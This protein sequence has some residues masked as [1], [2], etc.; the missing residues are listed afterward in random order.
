[1]AGKSP[2]LLS[3]QRSLVTEVHDPKTSDLVI[4][5]RGLGLQKIVCTLLQIYDGP[6]NLVLLI[7]ASGEEEKSI[8]SQLG[9]MGVRNPGLR[10]VDYEMSK[11]DRQLLYKKGG[12]ISVTSRILVVD[13]LQTDIPVELITGMVILHAEKVTPTSLESFVVRLFRKENKDGFVK[14]FSDQPEQ[15]T[16]GMFPLKS[17]ITELQLKRTHIYPRFHE[18]VQTS[19]S[20]RKADV[21]E[22]YV[23]MTPKMQD[24]HQGIVHCISATLN[25]LKKSNST[26][27]LD[28][29]TVEN[30]YFAS[31]DSIV[32]RQLDPVWH[33]IRPKTKQLVSDLG[34]LRR[35]LNYLLALDPITFHSYLES[36]VASNS[37]T[38][39]HPLVQQ[40]KSDW[41]FTEA[42]HIIITTAKARCYT[43]GSKQSVTTSNVD[44]DWA[45]LDE[46]Q[47]TGAAQDSGSQW[48]PWMPHEMQPVLEE[49]G[50][51]RVLAEV[52]L[53]IEHEMMSRPSQ[54]MEPGTNTVLVMVNDHRTATL[55]QE[56]LSSMHHNPDSP[57]RPLLERRLR[58]YLWWKSMLS[59]TDEKRSDD[60]NP[61]IPAR[62]S[63]QDDGLS[64][65]LRRKDQQKA[66]AKQARRRVRGGGDVRVVSEKDRRKELERS[67]L[68]PNEADLE[69]EAGLIADFLATQATTTDE[70]L[71]IS[72][73]TAGQE[74]NRPVPFLEAEE[75]PEGGLDAGFD[76]DYGL[77]TPEQI[78][79]VRVYGDDS[80]DQIL[81]EIRPRYIIV[82]DPNQDFIRR[83]EVYR[84]SNPG[85]A[86]RVYFMAYHLTAEEHKYL[87]G[88]RR[89]KDA[90][91]RLI[92]ERGSMLLT[93]GESATSSYSEKVTALSTRIGGVR[94]ETV[95]EAEPPRVI[96]DMREFRSS[97]PNL[98]DKARL[99]VVPA[100]LT[101]GDY[102]LTPDMCVERKSVPDLIQSF[103][104]GRLYTQC[105]L[106]SAHYNYP[107]LLIEFEE[108][109]LFSLQTLAETKSGAK[110]KQTEKGKDTGPKP[111]NANDSL[112]QSKLILLTLSF[113]RL[114]VI[115][116]SSPHASVDIIRELK[117]NF[118][119]PD[120]TKAI[121][122]GTDEDG[123]G[124][125]LEDVN[126]LAEDLL[127]ALPGIGTKNLRYVMNRV[128]SVA[129]LCDMS[130]E[131]LEELLGVEPG[132][133]CHEFIHTGLKQ[134]PLGGLLPQIR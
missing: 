25:E 118:S 116:S 81:H 107:I 114:R 91:E 80:D 2:F 61:A 82:Y 24:I 31:F 75:V 112:I 39:P 126:T 104:S 55:I 18:E 109:R 124:A 63:N 130:L 44:D 21:V 83:I 64:E 77:L 50:K 105:E 22:L 60:G 117:A 73:G 131:E 111:S 71:Y 125:Q 127:R 56:F 29:L 11:K 92:K 47:G 15:F 28:D 51:W 88:Q 85:L 79:A 42:A 45:I 13:L 121:S 3:Y 6:Q 89:E 96:V 5:G 1:M 101:V 113:P 19:L 58:S 98:L 95:A 41:L 30:A 99:Q 20:R 122:I 4:I 123:G 106:M 33:R 70:G 26:L 7:N 40:E 12:L 38:S 97:L 119:E 132:K 46:V 134:H 43:M 10:I 57:G 34:T 102:I 16:Q 84:S 65:A 54:L 32:R 35:L 8:G 103:N 78:V 120:V 36:I 86:V 129:A 9:T 90:F 62:R 23:H 49:P 128:G 87:A 94:G 59:K 76:D 110:K 74:I 69:V 48:L 72:A 53:E 67:G 66:A 37:S 108:S 133:K 93:I 27:D 115:W 100:T 68:M 14:A 52:L 17:V